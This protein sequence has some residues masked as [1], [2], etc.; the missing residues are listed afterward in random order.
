MADDPSNLVLVL[1]REIRAKQ[2]EHFSKLTEH[3][4]QFAT[5]NKQ[6]EHVAETGYVAVG[7]ATMTAK[8]IDEM[9]DR[10]DMVERRL[11]AVEATTR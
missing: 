4:Q 11:L 2:D 8:K 5:V 10:F 1:L 9:A 3:D 7:I 6:L